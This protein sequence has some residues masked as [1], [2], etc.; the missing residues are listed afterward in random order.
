MIY[1]PKIEDEK[2]TAHKNKKWYYRNREVEILPEERSPYI[3]VRHKEDG[4]VEKVLR[5]QLTDH[6]VTDPLPGTM[7]V[8]KVEPVL[9]PTPVEPIRSAK[10]VEA[11]KRAVY[12]SKL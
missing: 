1:D 6:I 7:A 12:Q 9:T 10:A 3:D 5:S 11:P 2:K 8:V 4:A